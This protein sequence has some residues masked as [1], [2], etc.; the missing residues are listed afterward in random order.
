MTSQQ[1]TLLSIPQNFYPVFN[2]YN[3]GDETFIPK[4]GKTYTLHSN[5]NI[6]FYPQNLFPCNWYV[7]CADKLNQEESG[8]LNSSNLINYDFQK[9]KEMVQGKYICVFTRSNPNSPVSNPCIYL[10]GIMQV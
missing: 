9:F 7:I 5:D 3:G 6:R 1:I 8:I 2:S 4:S 10:Q